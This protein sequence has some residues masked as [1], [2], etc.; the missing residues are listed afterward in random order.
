MLGLREF[1]VAHFLG[2][3]GTFWLW[4][5]LG[6][7]SGLETASL[8][9]V[10]VTDLFG[11][12]NER[13]DLLVMALF[14]S[15][16]S[17]TAGTANFNG[18]LF[19]AGVSDKFA[20]LLLNVSGGTRRFVDSAA[21]SWSLAIANFFQGSVALLHTFFDGL[22]FEGDL[23]G[24]LK[25]L[26]AHFFLSGGELCDIGVVA[27]LHILVG[28][29][30]DGILLQ[31]GDGLIFF[32]TTETG[33]GIVHTTA[34]VNTSLD[35]IAC[36]SH[37]TSRSISGSIGSGGQKDNDKKLETLIQVSLKFT[38]DQNMIKLTKN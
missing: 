26:F 16:N 6:H 29:L 21:L 36:L 17:G 33:L 20:R 34:E 4:V 12:I 23:T 38:Y 25:V 37:S 14:G 27:F 30:K 5:E 1:K 18:Q 15:F 10:Q 2:H 32:N 24:L 13:S 3:N 19:A 31:R 22:L 9:G 35:A 7:Q 8:L 28:T 11:N